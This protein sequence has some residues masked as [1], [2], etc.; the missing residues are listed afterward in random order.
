MN[1]SY[2][3]DYMHD[4]Q[5]GIQVRSS[6]QVAH[7]RFSCDPFLMKREPFHHPTVVAVDAPQSRIEQTLSHTV[8]TRAGQALE[9]INRC[10]RGTSSV[11]LKTARM[12]RADTTQGQSDR[13][14]AYY[15]TSERRVCILQSATGA[16]VSRLGAA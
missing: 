8:Q 7:H 3:G 6:E 16:G 1:V 2:G 4:L 15:K 14:L 13:S 11:I 5:L 9:F 12:S 10:K